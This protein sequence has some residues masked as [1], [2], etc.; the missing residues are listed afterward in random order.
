MKHI[1]LLLMLAMILNV[2][3]LAPEN[4]LAATSGQVVIN[5]IAWAGSLDN[6][7]DEWIELYNTTN[8]AI[9]LENWTIEDDTTTVYQITG[10]SIPSHGYFLIESSETAVMSQMADQIASLSFANTGDSLVLKDASGNTIDTV[11]GTGG[12]WYAGYN[13][14]KA[15]MERIDPL[16]TTDNG[17]NWADNIDSSGDTASGGSLIAGTP[18]TMNSVS[19]F[20]STSVSLSGSTPQPGSQWTVDVDLTDVSGMLSYG[21]EVAYNTTQ[22]ELVTVEQGPFLSA[23]Q[24]VATSFHEGISSTDTLLVGEA[25]TLSNKTTIDGDGRL[26]RLVFN[27]TGSA[28]DTG[29]IDLM[30]S[31]FVGGLDG[32]VPTAFHDLN[33]TIGGGSSSPDVV[34]NLAASEG[35][36]RYSLALSWDIPDSGAADS[37]NVYR[38][39]PH[40]VWEL[41]GSTT[42]TTFTD[43]DSSANGGN[44]VPEVDYHYE[45]TAVSGA[46]ESDGVTVNASD[47]RGVRGDTNRSDRVDGRD[48]ERLALHFA[49]DDTESS[50][51]PLIDTSFDGFIDGD[52]LIHIGANWAQSYNG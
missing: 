2:F 44:I 46:N 6:S 34:R 45:V 5:E 36:E 1:R 26:F 41:I 49:E 8:S 19:T 37:Y 13:T 30:G 27:V 47:T 52:D 4:A 25:R 22:L 17:D 7:N 14:S 38:S 16:V 43:N 20:A 23:N 18:K 35:T 29:T 42:E 15:T 11:N 39:N 51:D 40:D 50:F 48:L 21:V 10:G 9:S 31:S 28:D 32:D 12:M 24:S 33:Y 3:A